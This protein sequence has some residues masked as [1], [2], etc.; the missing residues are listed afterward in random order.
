M[1]KNRFIDMASTKE[2][3]LTRPSLLIRLRDARDPEAWRCFV[4]AYAPVVQSFL[5]RQGMQEADVMDVSQDVLVAV[6]GEIRRF[7]HQSDHRG[8]FRKWLFT[9]VRNRTADFW[10]RER[11]QTH[12]SGDSRTQQALAQVPMGGQDL[13]EQWDRQYMLTLFHAATTQ[14]KRDFQESTWQAFW[15][16][17]VDRQSA[18]AVAKEIGI[19][20]PAVYMAKRRV[21]QRIQQ[22]IEFLEGET[23]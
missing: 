21:L 12:G 16:T 7:E 18:Q 15:R 19:S 11:R 17:T 6:A 13:E 3:P 20:V 1:I 5:R 2:L 22:Q 14:V 9:I 10:R 4:E 8:S 23:I